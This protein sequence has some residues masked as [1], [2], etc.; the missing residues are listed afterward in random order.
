MSSHSLTGHLRDPSSESPEKFLIQMKKILVAQA[1]TDLNIFLKK[2]LEQFSKIQRNKY[3][4]DP[5]NKESMVTLLDK[6]AGC[7]LSLLVL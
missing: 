6:T 1:F 4:L 3:M 2:I 7:L 5:Y